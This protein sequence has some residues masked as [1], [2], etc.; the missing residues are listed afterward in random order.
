MDRAAGAIEGV[1]NEVE[2]ARM[3]EVVLVGERRKSR[4]GFFSIDAGRID[5][6]VALAGAPQ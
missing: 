5:Q 2:R 4:Y 3:I 1:V 6:S